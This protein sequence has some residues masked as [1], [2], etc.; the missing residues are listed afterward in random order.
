MEMYCVRV[1]V[2]NAKSFLNKSLAPLSALIL[3]FVSGRE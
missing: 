2:L 3:R 1:V